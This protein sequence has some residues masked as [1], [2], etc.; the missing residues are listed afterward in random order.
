MGVKEERYYVIPSKESSEG[1]IIIRGAVV[2]VDVGVEMITTD[3]LKGKRVIV[4]RGGAAPT[5]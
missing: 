5:P 3:T 2:V 4:R 1:G